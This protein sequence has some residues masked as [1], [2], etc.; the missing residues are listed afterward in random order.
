[1]D[2]IQICKQGNGGLFLKGRAS[3]I[4]VMGIIILILT[5]IYSIRLS[6]ADNLYCKSMNYENKIIPTSD[7]ILENFDMGGDGLVL[8]ESSSI[9]LYNIDTYVY[10]MRFNAKIN[11]DKSLKV[12]YTDTEGENFSET[13]SFDIDYHIV[14]G[15]P[16]IIPDR[17]MYSARIDF[18]DNPETNIKISSIEL[19]DYSPVID[20]EKLL[21]FALFPTMVFIIV[22]AVAIF[23]VKLNLYFSVFRKYIPL[24]SN[25]VLRDLRVKYRRSVLG[26]LWSILNPLL[27]ALIVN[28]VFSHI[29]RFSIDYFIVYYLMGSVLFNFM[30]DCTMGSMLSVIYAG[31][32][33][34]KVYIPKYIFPMQKCMFA[35]INMLFSVTAIV[36]MIIITGMPVTWSALLFPVPLLFTAVFS[37]GLGLILS[38]LTVFFRDIE[39]LYTVFVSAWIY[40]TPVIYPESILTDTLRNIMKLNPMYYYVTYFRG[41]V[42]YG[43]IPGLSFNL[44]CAAYSLLFLTAGMAVFKKYQD[45]FVLYI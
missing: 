9:Y 40:L 17:Y 45:R 14:N 35:F 29:F 43:E 23:G 16:V 3:I 2:Y 44:A 10:T 36:A 37:L 22:A 18:I 6:S 20:I 31:G 11:S 26:F 1:M 30:T 12:Y 8:R 24:I 33:I 28:A 39:H 15:R 7:M 41:L 19:N 21:A 13:K 5:T 4:A 27:M 34:K 32:L 38:S 25:L 42:M